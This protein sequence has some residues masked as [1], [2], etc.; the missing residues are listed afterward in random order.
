MVNSV[1]CKACKSE[2]LKRDDILL[3]EKCFI[4]HD[5]YDEEGP[6]NNIYDYLLIIKRDN[7]ILYEIFHRE[8]YYND[9]IQERFSL[10][11]YN[12]GECKGTIIPFR[13]S[14]TKIMSE[15]KNKQKQQEIF[16]CFITNDYSTQLFKDF[17][18]YLKNGKMF[19]DYD[20]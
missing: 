20:F 18:K 4:T 8:H 5:G 7:K 19:V 14:V 9:K 6:D 10:Y 17:I 16:R 15:F 12:G 2:Y 1:M 11:D 13:R 3:Y